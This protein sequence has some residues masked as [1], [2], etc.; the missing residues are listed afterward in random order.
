VLLIEDDF[1][2]YGE[3]LRARAYGPSEIRIPP[4]QN[5]ERPEDVL[6]PADDVMSSV[7]RAN[8]SAP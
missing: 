5:P 6:A 4:A 7:K 3:P 8:L 2:S 1:Q